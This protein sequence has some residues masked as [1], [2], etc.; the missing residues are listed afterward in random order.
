MSVVNVFSA[1]SSHPEIPGMPHLFWAPR[2]VPTFLFGGT[3]S[4]FALLGAGSTGV[5]A[6]VGQF[7]APAIVL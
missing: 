1:L 4:V 7:T 2:T 6:V 5:L 3:P